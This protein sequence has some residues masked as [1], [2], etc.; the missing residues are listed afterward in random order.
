MMFIRVILLVALSR[1]AAAQL[2]GIAPPKAATQQPQA[3]D[4][5][6]RSTPRGTI[7]GFT[8][9]VHRNDLAAA[10]RYLQL[11]D[12]QR[13]NADTLARKLSQ[14]IDRYYGEPIHS[15]DAS[16]TG[17]LDDGL[18]EDRE[19]IG[20]LSV[21]SKRIDVELVRVSDSLAGPVWLLSSETLREVPA[22]HRLIKSTWFERVMP[23]AFV[24]PS[25]FGVSLAQWIM[26]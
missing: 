13:P 3:D 9:A 14:L 6:G 5:L 1:A 17:A 8:E 4:P 22:L 21:D 23:P 20:P 16:R 2:P 11:N 26:P 15:I 7:T 18:P 24:R 10:V 25:L 12:S 19:R